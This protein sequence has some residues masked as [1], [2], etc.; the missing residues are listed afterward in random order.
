[1]NSYIKFTIYIKFIS[2]YLRFIN[3]KL[4]L[5]YDHQCHDM[6]LLLV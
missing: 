3:F 5:K 6:L 1:M 2:K 4:V